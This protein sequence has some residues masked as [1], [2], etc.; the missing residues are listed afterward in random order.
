[1]IVP[2]SYTMPNGGP[3]TYFYGDA[4]YS[5]LGA[6]TGT[7]YATLTGG[8]GELTDGVLPSDVWINEPDP[9]VGWLEV[10]ST[11]LGE[12]CTPGSPGCNPELPTPPTIN[13]QFAGSFTF[14]TVRIFVDDPP[15]QLGWVSAPSRVEISVTGWILTYFINATRT[16]QRWYTFNVDQIPADSAVTV[17]L[18]YDNHWIM[19]GEVEFW[20][21]V[22]TDAQDPDIVFN[23]EPGTLTLFA[24]GLALLAWHLR[25]ISRSPQ[26]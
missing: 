22:L 13:F 8:S 25:R 18:F 23:P 24:V 10:A 5:A 16:G 12:F 19:L 15:G 11:N 7:P 3:G 21:E 20:D 4:L 1:M 2:T 6:P 17:R 26:R 9:Y 14:R